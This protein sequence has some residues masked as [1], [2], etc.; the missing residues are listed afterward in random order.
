MSRPQ[1]RRF[2]LVALVALVASGPRVLALLA[3][4]TTPLGPMFLAGEWVAGFVGGFL[5]VSAG[6]LTA[7]LVSRVRREELQRHAAVR[8]VAEAVE[9]L[10]T[11]EMR[12]RR[13]V[14]DQ[15]HGNL[16][17]RMVT[18]TAGLD[19]VA[20]D[21]DQSCDAAG[22]QLADRLRGWAET[23]EEIR[24][25]E[26]RSLSHAVF[27]AG[28]EISM[29]RAVEAMLHRLPPNIAT[30]ITLGPNYRAAIATMEQGVVPLAERLIGVYAVE[31]AVTN[32]LKHGHATRI[33]VHVELVANSAGAAGTV[34]TSTGV[35]PS[36]Y[37]LDVTVTNDGNP[38]P[39]QITRS[40]LRRHGE[41]L[42]VRGGDLTLAPHPD[43]AQQG[44]Q[45]HFTLPFTPEEPLPVLPTP[46][47]ASA[48]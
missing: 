23:L 26:V 6:V 2:L 30:S 13:M 48:N 31:E 15:L 3:I 20:A 14:A 28:V 32:A 4:Y 33:D 35:G 1:N 11:E 36:P 17:Y 44:V 19:S 18:V 8:R 9:E 21:F 41:R 47:G 27:P 16:Q 29:M 42:Q 7:G 12:I 5:A 10:Q 22:R 24:E 39:A 40:G 43:G 37:L 45:L 46:A 38:L 25:S 34:G